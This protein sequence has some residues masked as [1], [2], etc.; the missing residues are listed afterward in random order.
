M[1]LLI[2]IALTLAT[3]FASTFL[4]LNYSGILTE[5][6]IENLL[7]QAKGLSPALLALL[8]AGCLFADLFIAVPTL[9][10]SLFAGFFLGFELG[11]LAVGSGFLAAGFTGYFLS[12][13]YGERLLRRIAD[14]ENVDEMQRLFQQHGLL[15]ILICRATPILPEVTACLSG[16]SRMPITKFTTAWLISSLTYAA[17]ATYAGSISTLQNPLPA[18]LTAIGISG[19]LGLTWLLLLRTR[20]KTVK[21]FSARK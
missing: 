11:F 20:R 10:I 19:V 15:M 9:T 7:N 4:L 1:K 6:Q 12:A 18:I 16:L 8:I 14:K 17:I 5:D 2:K 13:R 3:L 21:T